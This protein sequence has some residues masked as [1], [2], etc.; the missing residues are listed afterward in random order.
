MFGKPDV[1]IN[2][3][4]WGSNIAHPKKIY[5]KQKGEIKMIYR[6]DECWETSCLHNSCCDVVL[7]TALDEDECPIC[8]YGTEDCPYKIVD[9]F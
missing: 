8:L 9:I 4:L 1:V 5:I 3:Y 7:E 6:D 2:S